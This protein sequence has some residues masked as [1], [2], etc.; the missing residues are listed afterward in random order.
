MTR[1][2]VENWR[3][4][5][6]ASGLAIPDVQMVNSRSLALRMAK[7]LKVVWCMGILVLALLYSLV[8]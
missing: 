8:N 1:S 2:L 4:K 7:S 3:K 6:K 5:D